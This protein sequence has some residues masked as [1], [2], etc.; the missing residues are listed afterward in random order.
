[1]NWLEAIERYTPYNEQE[2][3]DKEL[4]LSYSKIFSD[5]LTRANELVHI[6]SSAFVI[7]KNRDKTLLPIYISQQVI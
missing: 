5:M 6:T 3:K 1:M 2:T 4:T 7:N